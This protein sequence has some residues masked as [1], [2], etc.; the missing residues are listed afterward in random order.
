MSTLAQIAYKSGIR[1][2]PRQVACGVMHAPASRDAKSD[3]GQNAYTDGAISR[4]KGVASLASHAHA[5]GR[6]THTCL[7]CWPHMH[8]PSVK[9]RR[10]RH[11]D[12]ARSKGINRDAH[13]RFTVRGHPM[14]TSLLLGSTLHKWYGMPR[15]LRGTPGQ[16]N[17]L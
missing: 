1:P 11:Y 14:Q 15:G 12:A 16:S 17:K 3:R 8:T 5:F 10:L 9:L 7:A 2:W 6:T 13:A 4:Q